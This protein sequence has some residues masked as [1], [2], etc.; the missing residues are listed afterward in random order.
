MSAMVKTHSY[1]E[2]KG[3][4]TMST[5]RMS[6]D[7]HHVMSLGDS[8]STYFQTHADTIP[9]FAQ[10]PT[11]KSKKDGAWSDANTWDMEKVPGASDVVLIA[12]TVVYDSMTGNVD[13]IGIDTGA[14]L[15]FKTDQNTK[16]SAANIMVFPGGTFRIGTKENPLSPNLTAEVVIKN[17]PLDTTDDGVGI[18]DPTQW[19]TSFLSLDGTVD[20]HGAVKNSTFVRLAREPQKGDTVLI[21]LHAPLGWREGDKLVLPDTQ[22]SLYKGSSDTPDPTYQGEEL[23]IKS[24]N[25]T[26][27]TLESPLA[28]DHLGARDANGML[29]F[30]PHV[31]NLSRNIVVRSE[32]PAGTRGHTAFFHRSIIDVEYALFKDRGRT[33]AI[34]PLASAVI[35]NGGA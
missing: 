13:A 21:L 26:T 14:G 27:L 31:A 29:Q 2:W 24:I 17:K 6:T 15:I 28:F 16:L 12:H 5:D 7:R 3:G 9:N 20:I 4:H 34:A 8:S 30:L 10:H 32:N 19:G 25:G 23:H 33:R 11:V 1:R 18:Y 35:K 22:S